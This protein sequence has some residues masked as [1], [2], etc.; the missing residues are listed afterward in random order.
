MNLS[1]P[2]KVLALSW[3]SPS[4]SRYLQLLLRSK[5][6][7]IEA[8]FPNCTL[9]EFAWVSHVVIQASKKSGTIFLILTAGGG[10]PEEM[11]L[12]IGYETRDSEQRLYC[13]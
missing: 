11:H 3:P 10:I 13:G 7:A 8:F 1:Q 9:W 6:K 2:R 12:Q 5:L 4:H